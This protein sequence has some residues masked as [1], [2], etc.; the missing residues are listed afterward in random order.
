MGKTNKSGKP[1]KHYIQL[2]DA[3]LEVAYKKYNCNHKKI[4]ELKSKIIG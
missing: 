2:N 4:K 3:E 1:V